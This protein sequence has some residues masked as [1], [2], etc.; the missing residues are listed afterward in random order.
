DDGK[1]GIK[2]CFR[3][4]RRSAAFL[5]AYYIY[6]YFINFLSVT[7]QNQCLDRQQQRLDPQQQRMH[8]PGRIDGVQGKALQGTGLGVGDDVMVVGI[9]ID[10]AAT[11]RRDA[12]EAALASHN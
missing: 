10:D 11:A 8:E 9:G 12:L 4:Q 7:A 5:S 1:P 6:A 2:S 3:K